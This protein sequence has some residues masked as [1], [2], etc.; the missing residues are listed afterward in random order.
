MDFD[1]TMEDSGLSWLIWTVLS[2]LVSGTFGCILLRI[3]AALRNA[4]R[5]TQRIH[6]RPPKPFGIAQ[7]S[8]PPAYSATKQTLPCHKPPSLTECHDFRK[9]LSSDIELDR[10]IKKER[11][12]L[13]VLNFPVANRKH[14]AQ[15][16]LNAC[17]VDEPSALWGGYAGTLLCDDPASGRSASTPCLP[18]SPRKNVMQQTVLTRSKRPP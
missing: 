13:S 7:K 1:Q 6:T 11:V 8:V 12:F 9:A 5:A 15:G 2:P 14:S 17:L 10:K 18:L 4:T 3:C 16:V